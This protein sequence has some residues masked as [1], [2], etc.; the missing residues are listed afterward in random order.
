MRSASAFV[1]Y[2]PLGRGLL[3]GTIR[4]AGDLAADDWRRGSPRYQGDNLAHNVALV[5]QLESLATARDCTQA[6]L[7]LAWVLAQGADIVPIPGT[8]R[9]AYLEQNV[10]ALDLALSADELAALDRIS[11]KGRGVR[12]PVRG[13]HDA[14][15]QPLS[16]LASGPTS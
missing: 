5:D 2:S 12:G 10:A 9:R 11:S 6:Q 15:P 14:V 3:G 16:T 1:A 8:K 7:A 4:Q 13:G